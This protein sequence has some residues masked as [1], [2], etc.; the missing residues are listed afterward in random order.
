MH[1]ALKAVKHCLEK[2]NKIYTSLCDFLT[3]KPLKSTVTNIIA[4]GWNER[5]RRE[6]SERTKK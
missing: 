6:Y 4:R 1:A 3:V 5:Y 2:K